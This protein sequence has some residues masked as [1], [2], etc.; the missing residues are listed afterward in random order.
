VFRDINSKSLNN[1]PCR[2]YFI[3]DAELAL[4]EYFVEYSLES[5]FDRLTTKVEKLMVDIAYSNKLSQADMP[6]IVVEVTKKMAEKEV[7]GCKQ[8]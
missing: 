2:E 8:Y 5:D 7:M 4:P 6:S 1:D 3:F